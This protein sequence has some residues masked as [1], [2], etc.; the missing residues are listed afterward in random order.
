MFLVFHRM[1]KPID[2]KPELYTHI[3]INRVL[4]RRYMFHSAVCRGKGKLRPDRFHVP[5]FKE[6]L[7]RP[8][9]PFDFPVNKQKW[10]S[11][12]IRS[13]MEVM[14]VKTKPAPVVRCE[15]TQAEK[16][17][18]QLLEECFRLYLSRILAAQASSAMQSSR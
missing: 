5:A 7:R 15:Y 13:G 3:R 2:L 4:I 18:A 11:V 6:L 16:S 9:L 12:N 14:R 1:T 10:R 17:L 8:R